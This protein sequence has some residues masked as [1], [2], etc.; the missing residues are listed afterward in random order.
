MNETHSL[1]FLGLASLTIFPNWKL[2]L[3]WFPPSMGFLIFLGRDQTQFMRNNIMSIV[4]E[5]GRL[6]FGPIG[7][8]CGSK[9]RLAGISDDLLSTLMGANKTRT[10]KF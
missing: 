8:C 9:L 1:T 3:V 10:M 5:V 4:P 6:A 7:S 2:V